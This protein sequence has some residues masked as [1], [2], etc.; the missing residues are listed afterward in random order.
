[1]RFK[2][3]FDSFLLKNYVYYAVEFSKY[4][5]FSTNT[6]CS[7]ICFFKLLSLKACDPFD[8]IIL[9]HMH[10]WPTYMT[11]IYIFLKHTQNDLHIFLHLL[12]VN[13]LF[14]FLSSY[15]AK[16]RL[17]K[18]FEIHC[19]IK[20]YVFQVINYLIY[21]RVRDSSET[22]VPGIAVTQTVR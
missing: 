2:N 5:H 7:K 18:V 13:G 21:S 16:M 20:S 10:I 8:A 3:Q 17:G 1:M 4:E 14:M 11:S 19:I 6:L 9:L 15:E 12:Q 22:N